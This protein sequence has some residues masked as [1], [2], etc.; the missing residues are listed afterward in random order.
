MSAECQWS[1]S[2]VTNVND[3]RVIR[4]SFWEN[5][6]VWLCSILQEQNSTVP[7]W[8]RSHS[9]GSVKTNLHSLGGSDARISCSLLVSR[10]RRRWRRWWPWSSRWSQRTARR[11]WRL[12]RR[13]EGILL[14]VSDG[15][16]QSS[17]LNYTRDE[18]RE[19]HILTSAKAADCQISA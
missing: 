2:I 4:K 16:N 5:E 18:V 14:V 6:K 19:K 13:G 17:L 11:T 3:V 10:W 8:I 7:V 12:S 1:S 15:A 9:I